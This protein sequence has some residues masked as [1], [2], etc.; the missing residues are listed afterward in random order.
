MYGKINTDFKIIK[1]VRHFV[2]HWL[3]RAQNLLIRI[4]NFGLNYKL[5]RDAKKK[6]QEH[7]FITKSLL[8]HF[9]IIVF[10]VG[11]IPT[12]FKKEVRIQNVISIEMLPVK[13]ITNVV[14]EPVRKKQKNIEEKKSKAMAKVKPMLKPAPPKPEEA[15]FK[16]KAKPK[17]KPEE[18]PQKKV[19]DF[20]TVLKSVES[21]QSKKSQKKVLPRD[22][23]PTLPLSVSEVDAIVKQIS[24][25]WSIPAGARDAKN[26]KVVLRISLAQDGTVHRVKIVDQSRYKNPSE[27]FFRAAADSAVR[28]AYKASPLKKL[29]VD[30]YSNWK[31][32]ELT[33]DPEELL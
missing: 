25:N 27:T 1:D 28:A 22:F 12:F 31:E 10:L 26:I 5:Y 29:P 32:L 6:V 17:A 20:D 15:T 9:L 16:S 11:G 4:D 19:D 24:D 3:N 21:M 13:D 30:K 18:K 7:P 2:N 14:P 23:N 8:L 33:F